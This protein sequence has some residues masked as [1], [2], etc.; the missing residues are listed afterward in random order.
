M[1]RPFYEYHVYA[2][3]VRVKE[4]LLFFLQLSTM[5]HI[6]NININV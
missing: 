5:Y 6:L 4:P 1:V 2:S 3:I